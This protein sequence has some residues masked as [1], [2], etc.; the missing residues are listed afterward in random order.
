MKLQ[1]SPPFL[2]PSSPSSCSPPF[3]LLSFPFTPP[4][5]SFPLLFFPPPPSFLF[6][7]P[8]SFFFFFFFFFLP[9]PL[10]S[11]SPPFPAVPFSCT[12]P[13]SIF[14]I[15]CLPIDSYC[16]CTSLIISPPHPLLWPSLYYPF[17]DSL[18]YLYIKYGEGMLGYSPI[19]LYPNS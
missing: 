17:I 1:P 7:S 6:V 2:M 14:P 15:D 11:S 9:P 4:P 16:I 5:L 10:L 19:P 8:P 3:P 18:S 12:P 13:P